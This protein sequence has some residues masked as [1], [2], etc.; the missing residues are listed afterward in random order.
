MS[1]KESS[2]TKI[3]FLAFAF[4][5]FTTISLAVFLSSTQ[6][7]FL[8]D[9]L[10]ISTGLGDYIGTLGFA[11]ELLSISIS[12]LL[13]ALSDKIGPK[14]INVSG[15]LLTGIALM[16][17]TTAKNVYPDLL[18]LRLFFSLGAT[19]GA[20]MLTAMLAELSSSGFELKSLFSFG[21]RPVEDQE[22]QS[23]EG[24]EVLQDD[25]EDLDDDENGTP[26]K[27]NGKLTSVI[28]IS[29]GL[30]AVFSV[31]VYLPLPSRLGQNEPAAQ[32]LKHSFLI[33]GGIAILSSFILAYA[34]FSE[35]TFK[36]PFLSKYLSPY[37]DILEELEQ[38]EQEHSRAETKSYIELLKLGFGEAKN[39]KIALAY[40]GAFVSRATTVAGAVF[41]PLYVN[42][43]YLKTGKCTAGDKL[44]C[45]DA[46]IRA[47]ILTGILNTVS[48]I[49]APLFGY[50]AD[51]FGRKNA[52]VITTISGM[53]GSLGFAILN[54]PL[55]PAAI[56]FSVFFGTAQIGSIVT[57]MSLATD[58][59]REHNGSIS[60]VYGFVG[61][62]G[63]LIISKLGG[64]TSDYWS[65]SPFLILALTHLFLLVA[66][67]FVGG[68]FQWLK[69]KLAGS[70]ALPADL[71]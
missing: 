61:G 53:I 59:H 56:V 47:A 14:Y 23:E 17:Y 43:Y 39:P 45:R 49:L 30:G 5:C 41:I 15:V 3:H 22:V 26:A 60:G 57:S 9:V 29:T 54:N 18:F 6:S 40:I 21:N 1:T 34:L 65:G 63:I 66:T 48:L 38:E 27:R 64:F 71:E 24:R 10:G 2:Y 44:H 69:T 33:V 51:K 31:A 52:L 11:D 28:G 36:I 67:L 25:F 37:D 35:K 55:S 12:P 62:I 13:G 42:S 19:A 58:K 20:G 32:A 16:V 4:S 46:Y 8:T 68:K 70:V 7:F 50:I